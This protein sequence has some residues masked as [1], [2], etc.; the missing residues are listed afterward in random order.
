MPK[1]S[2]RQKYRKRDIF[3]I[4]SNNDVNTSDLRDKT[5]IG[6][7]D[8]NNILTI[9][10]PSFPSTLMIDDLIKNNNTN[11]KPKLLPNAFIAY[12]MALMKE[13]HIRNR[14]LPPMGEISKIAKHSWN[15]EPRYVKD[16]YESLVK[17]AK[18]TYKQNNIQIVLDKHMDYV[19]NSQESGVAFDA[20][21]NED[22]QI[23]N[24]FSVGNSIYNNEIIFP[25]VGSTNISLINSLP[26]MP[27]E[28]NSTREYIR[29][30]EQTIEHLLRN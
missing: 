21:I 22:L 20:I 15:T 14:K 17:D 13:Y 19:E 5:N 11:N 9:L 6:G 26:E 2:L 3:F 18:L 30:L 28:M 4:N 27:H 25:S 29:M 1:I 12:R 10:K 8:P 23:Q 16:F 24:S 7:D